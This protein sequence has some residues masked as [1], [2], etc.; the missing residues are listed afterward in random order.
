[1]FIINVNP[2]LCDGCGSCA[3]ACPMDALAV[4]DGR[5]RPRQP[6]LCMGCRL[7]EVDCP[8]QAI[9]VLEQ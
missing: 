4:E 1:M 5:A 9:T 7:C 2:E 6:D 3:D 8:H